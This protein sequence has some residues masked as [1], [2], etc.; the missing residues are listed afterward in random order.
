MNSKLISVPL[1]ALPIFGLAA[2]PIP[3]TMGDQGL[4]LKVAICSGGLIQ[5]ASVRI[6]KNDGTPSPKDDSRMSGC[7]HVLRPRGLPKAK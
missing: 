1:L 4:V 6:P 5:S 3:L 2:A 7:A